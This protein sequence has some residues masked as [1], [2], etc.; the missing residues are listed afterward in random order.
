MSENPRSSV[1]TI[2]LAS[3]TEA[4]VHVEISRIETPKGERLELADADSGEC[5][6]L[7]AI[8][9]ESLTWQDEETFG[10]FRREASASVSVADLAVS[11]ES[12]AGTYTELTSITNEFSHVDVRKTTTGER[13]WVELHGPKVGFTIRLNAPA[14]LTVIYQGHDR[15]TDLLE[16]NLNS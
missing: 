12:Y 14:A 10:E 7:D 8:V 13:E 6:W 11:R 9:L 4:D 1:T 3:V 15:F 16:Q 2:S 5:I